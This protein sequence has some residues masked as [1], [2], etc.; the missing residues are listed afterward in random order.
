MTL[1]AWSDSDH[2]VPSPTGREKRD[3]RAWRRG[4]RE[5]DPTGIQCWNVNSMSWCWINVVST[6]CACRGG[7][8][9]IFFHIQLSQQIQGF[10]TGDTGHISCLRIMLTRTV[11]QGWCTYQTGN[12][13]PCPIKNPNNE[14][15]IQ[16]TFSW[17][18]FVT[19]KDDFVQCNII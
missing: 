1:K 14:F 18:L 7:I 10:L 8:R 2:F 12:M 9:D 3:R 19:I 16:Q 4:K 5:I 13:N 11:R 17:E 6:L 15:V